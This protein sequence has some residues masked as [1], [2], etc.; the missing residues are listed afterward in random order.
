MLNKKISPRKKRQ[1]RIR[2]KISGTPS[3][4]R[5]NVFRSNLDFYAQLIDDTNHKTIAS[6]SIKKNNLKNNIQGCKKLGELMA[7]EIKK[8]KIDSIVFDRAGY[9]YSGKVKS[10][11]DGCRDAGIKF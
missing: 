5:L 7:A 10:F 2:K 8:L 9:S 4:P 3:K 6:V 11:A 1:L